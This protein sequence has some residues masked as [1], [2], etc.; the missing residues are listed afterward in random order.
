MSY[1]T[2]VTYVYVSGIPLGVL[3]PDD[4]AMRE[5]EDALRIAERSGDDLAVAIARM[6][7]GLALVHRQTA[8]ERD[9]GQK[10]LAE[11]RDMC[12]APGGTT[13]ASY[14]SST[15]TWRVRGP[16]WEI[17]MR[18]YR[19]CA[20][21]S[22]ICSAR[23]S[24]CRGAFLRPAVLVETLLDRG[25]DAD[26]AEAEAAIERLAA[27]PADE[28]LVIR[29]I[30]LLRLRALLARAHG[31]EAALPRTIGIATATWRHRLASRGIS[32]GPRRCHDGGCSF[33]G[34][35]VSVHRRRGFDPSVGG[36]RRWRCGW[37]WPPMTRCC[38]RRSRRTAVGHVQAHR[39]WCVRRVRVTEV[40]GGCRDSRAAGT[41]IAGAD[42]DGDRR[43]RA[44]R[45]ATTSARCSIVPRG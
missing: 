5:I 20:P 35:D 15:C 33:G 11:V 29:D 18:P 9:R 39:R 10:L 23:D 7:L 21:P 24:C 6:T 43:G 14:R 12:P 8:A 44:A 42:G 25:A 30:W 41:G 36:R 37:R 3:R 1:A 17:A 22:T 28:G 4:S 2:V 26:V 31:D 13:C 16:G 38:A 40:S 34:G 27:A 19:S 32:R 45:R